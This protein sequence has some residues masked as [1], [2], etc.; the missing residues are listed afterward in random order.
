MV[1]GRS[2]KRLNRAQIPIIISLGM[3]FAKKRCAK[4]IGPGV[5]TAKPCFASQYDH[6][7]TLFT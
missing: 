3:N 4:Q 7:A 1:K 5:E 6:D 2:Y